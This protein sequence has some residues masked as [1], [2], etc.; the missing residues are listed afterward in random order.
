MKKKLSL[1]IVDDDPDDRAFFIDAAKEVDERIEC[2]T[3]NDGQKALS[4]LKQMEY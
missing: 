3:A 1:L 4:L 2:I